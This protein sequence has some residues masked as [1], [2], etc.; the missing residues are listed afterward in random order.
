VDASTAVV[1]RYPGGA[2]GL[3]YCGLW[4]QSPRVATITGTAGVITV[5]SATGA[6]FFK[7]D[8]YTLIPAHGEPRTKQITLQGEGFTYEA[9]EVARCLRAGL[10]ESPVMSLAGTLDVMRA[11]DA[12]R[13]ASG[14]IGARHGV[15]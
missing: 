8:S 9:A 6:P 13:A 11:L 12:A 10:T 14:N 3:Y 15:K 1:A 4:A 2:I 7:P 5:G